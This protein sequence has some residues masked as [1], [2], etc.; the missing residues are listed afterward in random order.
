MQNLKGFWSYVHKDDKAEKGRISQL[1]HDIVDQYEL[2]TGDKIELFL[3]KD[4]I[5]WGDNWKDKID[6]NL[7]S[8]AFFIPVI[9]PRYLMSVEC[10][11]EMQYFMSRAIDKGISELLLPLLYIKIQ[12]ITESKNEDELI[13]KIKDT[14]YE[15]WTDIR[16]FDI[17][18]EGYRRAVNNLVKKLV[19]IN[20]KLEI[21]EDEIKKNEKVYVNDEEELGFIDQLAKL[22]ETMPEWFET[23]SKLSEEMGKVGK[24]VQEETNKVNTTS[25]NS[26][27]TFSKR[28]SIMRRL[29]KRLIEPSENIWNLSNKVAIQIN[30]VDVGLKILI[31]NGYDEIKRDPTIKEKYFEYLRSMKTL[32]VAAKESFV[33]IDGMIK[34]LE[35]VESISREI[36]PVI[37]KIK[38]GLIIYCQ[39][40]D[41]FYEWN[42]YIDKYITER[43]E[44]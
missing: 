42:K 24:I 11:R 44:W 16:F 2:I 6:R 14:Q 5:K 9:T 18:S 30:T 7:D 32:V 25:A 34:S 35:A 38:Q 15:D 20:R 29:A 40:K 26:A 8:I 21:S 37:R 19:E 23:I 13:K 41:N 22:E 39:T 36:R 1:V 10:R 12:Q 28:L 43:R 31:E 27:D 33:S 17:M 3:D 4:D